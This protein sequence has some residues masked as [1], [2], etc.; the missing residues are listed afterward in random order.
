MDLDTLDCVLAALHR[1][2]RWILAVDI[3]AAATEFAGK[4]RE[5]GADEVMVVAATEGVGDLPDGVPIHYTRSRGA[6]VMEGI[7]AFERAVTAPSDGLCAD[8][9][10]FDPDRTARV[11][12]PPTGDVTDI[13]GRRTVG[14]RP[15]AWAAL[16]DK[17]VAD[18]LWDAAGIERAPSAVVPLADAAD[19]A[20][21]L[22]TELGSVWVADNVDGWHGGAEFPAGKAVGN[23]FPAAGV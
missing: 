4:L 14:A 18:E 9:E 8:V 2:R 23:R 7:R 1:D 5:W 19:A 17:T 10:R 11:I 12:A 16:E 20:R 15:A 22:A 6:T 21:D 13:C 3:A